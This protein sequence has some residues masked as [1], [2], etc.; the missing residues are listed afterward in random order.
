MPTPYA[1][2]AQYASA[3]RL[4]EDNSLPNLLR[5]TYGFYTDIRATC[6]RLYRENGEIVQTGRGAFKITNLFGPDA[7]Q[8]VLQNRD[9]LFSSRRGWDW[10]ID[11]VFP[12]AIMSMD[13]AEH[14]YQ[15][16]IMQQAFKKHAL[17]NYM[18]IMQ[19]E[20]AKGVVT[21][22]QQQDF[23][24]YDHIK[25][26]TLDLAATVFM[27]IELG[28]EADQVNKAFV[29]TVEAS[30]APIRW[31]VPGTAMAKGVRGRG[32]LKKVFK[33]LLPSKRAKETPDFFSQFCHAETE[34]GQRF[35]D[36]EI[37]DH[38]IFLMM[39]AHDTTTSTLTTIFYA[40]AKNPDWQQKV[41]EEVLALN[42]RYLSFDDLEKLEL[43]E[44]V[45]KEALRM[46][47]PLPTM[48]RRLKM[49]AEYK[50]YR[51]PK[52]SLVSI[53]P[54]HSH[55][56]ETIWSHPNHFDPLRFAPPREEYKQHGFAW[57]PFG[58]GAHMCIGQHFAVLQVKCIMNQLLK[59]YEWD[60]PADYEMPYQ[61][62]PIAKPKDGLPI[63]LRHL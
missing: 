33:R 45:M 5:Y 42:T 49:A 24:L 26:L 41:R 58:G 50:G 4:P 63:N 35:T 54:I 51:L 19:P 6:D 7:N 15:R 25:K 60:V 48:P 27:G 22:H 40:L 38:M 59:L 2:N 31:A 61:L 13:G 14:R 52:N 55:Y 62:V 53:S 17:E 57:I 21:W 30:I 16:R 29:D 23:L 20:I 18:S 10:V 43:L 28:K 9:D 36:K 44:W 11:K 46:Y 1:E 37:T 56:M 3:K 12:G 32:Y 8:W 47:P 39:A 34:D